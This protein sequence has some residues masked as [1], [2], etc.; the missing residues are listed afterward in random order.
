M[1][2]KVLN[3]WEFIYRPF[4][5][6]L[7]RLNAFENWI[8]VRFY[9]TECICRTELWIYFLCFVWCSKWI[10]ICIIN[11]WYYLDIFKLWSM[12]YIYYIT[13]VN[14][15]AIYLNIM[16]WEIILKNIYQILLFFCILFY[17]CIYIHFRE[18]VRCLKKR[19]ERCKG[20][21][22]ITVVYIF[23]KNHIFSPS[24]F[25]QNDIFSPKYHTNKYKILS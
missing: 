22:L 19:E 23:P 6:T 24:P 13:Y 17:I 16:L 8:S 1:F 21:I 11:D 2:L 18:C 3:G 9:E 12:N 14:V 4:H 10:V 7:L 15:F 25:F 5:K 20:F